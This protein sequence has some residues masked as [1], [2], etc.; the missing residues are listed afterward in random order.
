MFCPICKAE[1]RPGI[2]GCVDCNVELVDKLPEEKVDKNNKQDKEKINYEEVWISF[3]PAEVMFVKSI[4][5]ETEMEYYFIGENFQVV[6]PLVEPIRLMVR[7]D[8]VEKVKEILK[9]ID[10][11]PKSEETD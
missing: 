10:F 2:T 8:Y 6:Q 1:Y 5:A 11:T 4:L 7:K 3:N 9:D